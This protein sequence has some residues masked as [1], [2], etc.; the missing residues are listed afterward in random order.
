M[1]RF[2]FYKKYDKNSVP[3]PLEEVKCPL[4]DDPEEFLDMIKNI[5]YEL[6]PARSKGAA[7]FTEQVMKFSAMFEYDLEIETKEHE[8]EAKLIIEVLSLSGYCKQEFCKLLMFADDVVLLKNPEDKIVLI[9][10]YYTHEAYMNGRK[11]RKIT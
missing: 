6:V 5:R 11:M 3:E 9:L 2:R 10:T 7:Q 8:V 4:P 1:Q